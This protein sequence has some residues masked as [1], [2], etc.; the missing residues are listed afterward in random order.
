MVIRFLIV[1]TGI[2]IAAYTSASADSLLQRPVL[3]TYLP[4]RI[5]LVDFTAGD[6]SDAESAHAISQIIA[7]DLKESGQFAPIN[8]TAFV[9]KNVSVGETPQFA[10][11]R[12]INAQQLVVGRITRRSDGRT[13][14]EF[15]LWDVPTGTQ[16]LGQQ[17]ISTLD[18]LKRLGHLI[19][20]DI[21]QRLTGE[22]VTFE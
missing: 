18:D 9:E 22:K 1:A 20:G 19:S 8:P 5:A 7:F 2:L 16:L 14:I 12:A 15:R 10:D 11:W 17:Y 21:Y 4:V 13:K 3:R 6:V